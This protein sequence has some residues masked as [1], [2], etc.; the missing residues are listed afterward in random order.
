MGH[1]MIEWVYVGVVIAVLCY[2]GADAWNLER[3]LDAAL[4]MPKS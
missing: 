3:A 2:V 1:G 4:L